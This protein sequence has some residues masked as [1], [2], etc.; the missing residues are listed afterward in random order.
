HWQEQQLDAFSM[1]TDV[2]S[3]AIILNALARI[4]PE[5]PLLPQVVRWLMTIREQNGHWSSTQETAWSVLGLTEWLKASGELQADYSWQAS[6]NGQS[7]DEGTVDQDNLD[8]TTELQIAVGQLVADAVN[9]FSV[10]RD[11]AGADE[12]GNLYYGAYLTY[13]KPVE[14]VDALDRGIIVSRRYS[15]QG[16]DAPLEEAEVGDFIDVTLT[17]IAPNDLHYVMV[18]DYL[19]AGTE[20]LDSSL[21]TTSL[22]AGQP[23]VNRLDTDSPWGSWYFTHTDLRD[24]KAVLFA[25]SLPRGAYE[26]TYTVRAAVP[27]TYR[28]IPTQAKETYFP[29]VF[30]RGA[31]DVLRIVE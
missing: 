31:G 15:L 18:E 13:Y 6:L 2:R 1:N 17:V 20:A 29:E 4:E 10:E 16:S 9:R 19:P 23:T 28:V 11:S 25:D 22:L 14:A 12:A 8:E 5:N 24:E 3:T 30:G 26:Y 21:A 7:L 27:G